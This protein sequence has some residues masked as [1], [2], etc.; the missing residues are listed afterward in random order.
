MF[1]SKEI[2]RL[3][4][5]KAIGRED[6]CG[7]KDKFERNDLDNLLTNQNKVDDTT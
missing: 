2:V 7:R 3:S 1:E 5:I 6:K 4:R